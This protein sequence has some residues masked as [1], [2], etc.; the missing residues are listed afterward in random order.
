MGN[1]F[2]T[3][4]EQTLERQTIETG[5]LLNGMIDF[6]VKNADLVDLYA[7]A[8]PKQCQKY[9]IL[10]A[11]T[12]HKQF[13]LIDLNPSTPDS[14]VFIQRTDKLTQSL[15]DVRKERCYQVAQFFVRILHIFASISLTI[16]DMDIPK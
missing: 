13:K 16:I 6:M 5:T 7:L 1:G 14:S 3:P 15:S 4:I 12:L 9:I 10:T 2:G 8:S 11:D